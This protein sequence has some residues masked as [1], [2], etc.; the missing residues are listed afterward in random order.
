MKFKT[1]FYRVKLNRITSNCNAFQY[2]LRYGVAL[3][4]ARTD[5]NVPGHT[6]ARNAKNCFQLGFLF[7]G[8]EQYLKRTERFIAHVRGGSRI[9]KK[10]WRVGK[11]FL[12]IHATR[13][14]FSGRILMLPSSSSKFEHCKSKPLPCQRHI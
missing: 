8:F 9:L 1:G 5:K 6:I 4:Y 10:W 13:W 3:F 14:R 2:A 7:F 11:I 12:L